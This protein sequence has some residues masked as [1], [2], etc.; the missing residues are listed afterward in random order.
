MNRTT[1]AALAVAVASVALVTPQ[2][3]GDPLDAVLD[4]ARSV[5]S[6]LPDDVRAGRF[7]FP[8]EGSDPTPAAR[9]SGVFWRTQAGNVY[10][11]SEPYDAALVRREVGALVAH[12]DARGAG[13]ANERL[14]PLASGRFY[15]G[16]E[17]QWPF[18]D[19]VAPL[20]APPVA[21]WLLRPAEGCEKPALKVE[22]A[23]E[24]ELDALEPDFR[25]TGDRDRWTV[26][27]APLRGAVA[28]EVADARRACRDQQ[29]D[30]Y[31][32]EAVVVERWR[33]GVELRAR[34]PGGDEE[35]LL[36]VRVTPGDVGPP[37]ARPDPA[38]DDELL[39]DFLLAVSACRALPWE[40][41]NFA[42]ANTYHRPYGPS[43]HGPNWIS[44]TEW[45]CERDVP[46]DD[47]AE[48]E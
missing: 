15:G 28:D 11:R 30:D 27:L 8:A 42:A 38:P 10:T 37:P 45:V 9:W 32:A 41:S 14:M 34:Y 22:D 43:Y 46:P 3:S 2:R 33:G 13:V 35:D 23:V 19:H 7:A 4:G 21:I 36:S 44:S 18:R 5:L 31:L 48:A 16:S 6:F 24:A 39:N 17:F 26:D 40:Y 25:P 12:L 20:L 1:V 29:D 47:R